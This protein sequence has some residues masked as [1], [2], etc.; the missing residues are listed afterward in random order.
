[1]SGVDGETLSGGGRRNP[2]ER[3]G[4]GGGEDLGSAGGVEELE[5][6]SNK[7]L[8]IKSFKDD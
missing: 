1:M 8:S 3:M 7:G 5:T 2:S 6:C 4:S